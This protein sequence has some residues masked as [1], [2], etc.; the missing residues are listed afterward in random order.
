MPGKFMKIKTELPWGFSTKKEEREKKYEEN[1]K[2][3][4]KRERERK[5]KSKKETIEK[6]EAF[7][8]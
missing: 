1:S 3:K 5:R 2:K 4:R 6:V 8:A 7:K